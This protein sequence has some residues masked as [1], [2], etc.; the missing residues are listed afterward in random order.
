[1]YISLPASQPNAPSSG[2]SCKP[3]LQ[4]RTEVLGEGLE[5]PHVW[6]P[7]FLR[8]VLGF[9]SVPAS[10]VWQT[11]CPG[12]NMKLTTFLCLGA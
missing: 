3:F 8:G 2:H 5:L 9:A 6:E 7:C 11:W 1:M 10:A 12:A 4:L